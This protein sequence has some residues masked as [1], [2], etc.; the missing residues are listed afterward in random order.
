MK[1]AEET[2]INEKVSYIQG[3]DKFNIVKI[4]LPPNVIYIY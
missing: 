2:T 3:P 4:S 1:E